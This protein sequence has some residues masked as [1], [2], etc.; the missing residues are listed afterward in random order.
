[1]QT[2]FD[3]I[4][5]PKDVVIAVVGAFIGLALTSLIG[6]ARGYRL[7]SPFVRPTVIQ[8][9]S[10]SHEAS[11]GPRETVRG[12]IKPPPAPLRV[13]VLS[14]DGWHLQARPQVVGDTWSV[15]CVFG[16]DK[17]STIERPYQVI[18]IAG[19]GVIEQPNQLPRRGARSRQ[20]QVR[21]PPP[22]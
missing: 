10:P 19:E 11:V 12:T 7:R 6:Y 15:E 9:T 21:R 5:T 4:P 20:I 18:A 16:D 13:F 1:M 8:I 22:S 2:L 14:H 3:L 17:S